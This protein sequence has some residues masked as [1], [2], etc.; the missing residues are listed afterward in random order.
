MDKFRTIK[1]R[2][3]IIDA[4]NKLG[5]DILKNNKARCPLH[6]DK[7][8]SLSFKGNRFKC[9]SCNISGDVIDLTASVKGVTLLDAAKMLDLM[10]GLRLFR[11]KQNAA[12]PRRQSHEER[13]VQAAQVLRT[14][15]FKWVPYAAGVWLSY[16]WLLRDWKVKYAP[17]NQGVEFD[18]RFIEALN[19]LDHAEHVFESVFICGVFVDRLLFFDRNEWEVRHLDEQIRK[20]EITR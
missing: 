9:F 15:F 3:N 13:L 6:S 16:L 19:E 8:P 1:E 5:I 20:F 4:A 7:V 18:A 11:G 12:A 14:C 2:V 10:Y 17:R